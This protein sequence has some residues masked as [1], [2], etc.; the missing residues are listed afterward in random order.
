M[1]A[2]TVILALLTAASASP[3]RDQFPSFDKNKDL[4]IFQFDNR[5]DPDD[6]HSQAAVGS[7]IRH[8]DFDGVNTYAVL[9]A[10]GTQGHDILNSTTLMNL[11]FGP[12]GPDTWT[13]A[14]SFDEK[15]GSPNQRWFRSVERVNKIVKPVLMNGG[16]VWVME[17]GNKVNKLPEFWDR[18]VLAGN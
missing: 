6:I 3:D 17:P 16:S 4:L 18:Y 13:D 1:V 9:G 12:E 11:V 7:M 5:P 15:D 8:S 2:P 10:T 14:R